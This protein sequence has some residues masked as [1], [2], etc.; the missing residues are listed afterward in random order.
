MEP[1]NKMKSWRDSRDLVFLNIC[2]EVN[3]FC[4]LGKYCEKRDEWR[5]TSYSFAFYF[6]HFFYC[7]VRK[8]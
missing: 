8:Q 6:S 3:A 4:F 7:S 1:S 5:F 2:S